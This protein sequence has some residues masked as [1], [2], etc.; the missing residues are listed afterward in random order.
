MVAKDIHN[1]CEFEYIVSL[2][3][4]IHELEID[5]FLEHEGFYEEFISDHKNWVGQNL[6]HFEKLFAASEE[7]RKKWAGLTMIDYSRLESLRGH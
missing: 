2:M 4:L 7:E 5:E 1:N 6:K 3:M